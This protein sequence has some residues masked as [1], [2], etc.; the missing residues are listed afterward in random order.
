VGVAVADHLEVEVVG[1]PATAEH[2]IELLPGLLPGH[3]AMHGVGG[4]ALG[5]MDG[6]GVAETGRGSNVITGQPDGE[7]AA[8]V[9]DSEP[10]AAVDVGDGP[11]VA[12]FTQSVAES[13]SWRSLLRVM[14]TSPTLARFPSPRRTSCPTGAP[15][16]R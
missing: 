14:I 12:V 15:S 10:T 11:A 13:R 9:S 1:V 3:Q 7:V 6:G 4:D 8:G 5:G 2:R 16:R